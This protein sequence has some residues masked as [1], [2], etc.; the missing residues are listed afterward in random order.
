MHGLRIGAR[1]STSFTRTPVATEQSGEAVPRRLRFGAAC[2][3]VTIGRS[4]RRP[5]RRP[6]VEVGEDLWNVSRP[7]GAAGGMP[8]ERRGYG[9]RHGSTSAAAMTAELPLTCSDA[10][11]PVVP[12]ENRVVELLRERGWTVSVAES[13]TAGGVAA[14]LCACPG[15]GDHVLGGVVTYATEAKRRVLGVTAEH[16]VSDRASAEMAD[17]VRLLFDSDVGLS[18]T[19]VAGPDRQDGRPVGNVFVG[20]STPDSQGTVELGCA[21]TPEQ[22]RYESAQSALDILLL[23][24]NGLEADGRR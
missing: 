22:I 7:P 20:W 17:G 2:A 15:T 23:A 6:F 12:V 13:L 14:R 19:G 21:G 10:G 18:V 4:S 1:G 9:G 5:V 11:A 3:S 24:L 16:V 8:Q